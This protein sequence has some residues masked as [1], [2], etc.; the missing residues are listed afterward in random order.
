MLVV[1]V[2][3]VDVVSN[4][5]WQETRVRILVEVCGVF[6]SR[7]FCVFWLISNRKKEFTQVCAYGFGFTLH[8]LSLC[9]CVCV[10]VSVSVFV[11]VG[12]WVTYKFCTKSSV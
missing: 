3:Y 6:V 7:V 5:A 1:I 8:D 9:V 2:A 11:G 12:V 4:G 10:C